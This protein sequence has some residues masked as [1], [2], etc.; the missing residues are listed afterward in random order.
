MNKGFTLV[1]LSIVL[2]IIGLLIGGILVGQ[3][4]IESAKLNS[5]V[6]QIAQYDAGVSSF[7]SKFRAIPGD[8]GLA[9]AKTGGG[10]DGIVT[11]NDFINDTFRFSAAGS[12]ELL[13]FWSDLAVLS[14]LTPEN[15][16]QLATRTD[17]F[18]G[19]NGIRADGEDCNIAT[20]E[21]GIGASNIIIAASFDDEAP[22]ATATDNMSVA[23]TNGNAYYIGDCVNGTSSP[24]RANC[25]PSFSQIQALA[26]DAKLDDGDANE[27]NVQAFTDATYSHFR[28]ND[29]NFDEYEPTAGGDLSV[30]IRFAKNH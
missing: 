30:V 1:E 23:H 5:F 25:T 15:C 29:K 21:Y 2:V 3:S 26:I 20:T 12:S 4:L 7:Y 24:P 17:I 10:K 27:G 13:L 28:L 14:N 6:R 9:F 18:Q 11:D 16:P 19:G 22:T 8:S